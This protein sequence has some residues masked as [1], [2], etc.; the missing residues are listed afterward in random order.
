MPRA[1]IEPPDKR[2]DAIPF[3]YLATN[4]FQRFTTCSCST[5]YMLLYNTQLQVCKTQLRPLTRHSCIYKY[6]TIRFSRGWILMP[7]P[8]L[9]LTFIN[10]ISNKVENVQLQLGS[11]P[12]P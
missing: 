11:F 1:G 12:I 9:F 2:S 8:Y 4:Q 3:S 7:Q 10:S 6:I 5:D